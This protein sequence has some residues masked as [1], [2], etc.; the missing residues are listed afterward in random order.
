MIQSLAQTL[1]QTAGRPYA[2]RAEIAPGRAAERPSA[3]AEIAPERAI[4]PIFDTT[5]KFEVS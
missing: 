1:A 3:S 2:R 5:S 4:M